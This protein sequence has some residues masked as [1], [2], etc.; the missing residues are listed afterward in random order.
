MKIVGII[1]SRYGSKRFPGKP[2]VNIL[3][4]TMVQ[5]V[6]EQC[7]KSS[8]LTDVIIATDDNRIYNH[9]LAFGGKV[10]MT[11]KS[12]K[13]GTERCN[14]VAQKLEKFDVIVNIQGDEPFID[15]LQIDEI[16]KL[17]VDPEIEIATLAKKIDDIQII[18]DENTPKA[19]FD[20]AG[21]ALN[22][23]RKNSIK[24]ADVKY[25]KHIGIYAY[26]KDVLEKI[27][28]LPESKNERRERLEQLR[29]L[30]NNYKIKV[31]ITNFEALSI[32]TPD[33][34]QKIKA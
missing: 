15:P 12:H 20:K 19:I 10:M 9:V 6:Y 33:D 8:N 32:D 27:C 13:T 17:S 31:G 1:P 29:W 16:I 24:S 4:K 2:L 14:E 26:K 11:S 34:L 5:R 18:E 22:F 23:Y 21:N 28:E 25:Y 7:K 30:D 3:G